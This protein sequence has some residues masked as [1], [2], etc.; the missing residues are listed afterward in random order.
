MKPIAIAVMLVFCIISCENSDVVYSDVNLKLSAAQV[1]SEQVAKMVSNDAAFINS[2]LSASGLEAGE[3]VSF[4]PTE[5]LMTINMITLSSKW[6]FDEENNRIA[7][8]G[9]WLNLYINRQVDL[10]SLDGLSSI[11]SPW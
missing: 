9:D 10:V 8:R 4:S 1:S 6:E 2:A 3:F 11:L 7:G 5:V